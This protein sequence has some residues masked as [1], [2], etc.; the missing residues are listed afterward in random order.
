[1]KNL[2]MLCNKALSFKN[3]HL[4]DAYKTYEFR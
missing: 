3:Q 4:P 1:M 2:L